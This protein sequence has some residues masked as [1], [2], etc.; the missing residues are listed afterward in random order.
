M[1][2]VPV[3]RPGPAAVFENDA[4]TVFMM[5]VNSNIT[6]VYAQ[7]GFHPEARY[8]FKVNFDAADSEDLTYRVSF[9]GPDSDGRQALCPSSPAWPCPQV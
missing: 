1:T 6:G 8:E 3:R 2:A 4:S 7:P 9:A 5:D